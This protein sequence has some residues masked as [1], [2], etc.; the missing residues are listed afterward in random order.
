[1][2]TTKDE[3]WKTQTALFSLTGENEQSLLVEMSDGCSTAQG[4]ALNI[5]G[6]DFE[7]FEYFVFF[8]DLLLGYSDA[9]TTAG[10]YR[11]DGRLAY[12]MPCPP[13]PRQ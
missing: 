3:T 1:M 8:S 12:A 13:Q 5:V 7:R 2:I 6:T 11:L 9:L 10:G 4:I